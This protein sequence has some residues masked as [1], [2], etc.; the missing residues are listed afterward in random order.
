MDHISKFFYN[1]TDLKCPKG[2]WLLTTKSCQ[3]LLRVD[4]REGH[5][6]ERVRETIKE[7]LETTSN[8]IWKNCIK[9][10]N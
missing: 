2:I 10:T 1:K 8:I 9:E 7:N 5:N 4:N 3:D 6:G